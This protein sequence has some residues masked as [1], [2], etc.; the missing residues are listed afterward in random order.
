MAAI[1]GLLITVVAVLCFANGSQIPWLKKPVIAI[2]DKMA[3]QVNAKL[4]NMTSYPQMEIT[5]SNESLGINFFS[6]ALKYIYESPSGCKAPAELKNFDA[7]TFTGVT[8]DHS[9]LMLFC[10]NIMSADYNTLVEEALTAWGLIGKQ[11]RS[12]RGQTSP[13]QYPGENIKVLFRLNIS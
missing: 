9:A 8:Y 6:Q 2:A 11:A 7:S 13:F 12:S 3:A 1:N 5:A 10:Q 4:R